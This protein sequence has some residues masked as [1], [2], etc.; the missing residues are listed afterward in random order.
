MLSDEAPV[1][2]HDNS[3]LLSNW[4]SLYDIHKCLFEETQCTSSLLMKYDQERVCNLKVS[5][6]EKSCFEIL[7]YALQKRYSILC[8]QIFFLGLEEVLC[9]NF[10]LT[11]I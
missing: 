6:L 11:S 5:I 3:C 4:K 7:S 2:N 10:L 9:R 8:S 1:N